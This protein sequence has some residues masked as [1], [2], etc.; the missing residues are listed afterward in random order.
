[1]NRILAT[2]VFG[3]SLTGCIYTPKYYGD[4]CISRD[5][6]YC[7]HL[8]NQW[9]APMWGPHAPTIGGKSEV[10]W[11]SLDKTWLTK[12]IT[13]QRYFGNSSDDSRN[14]QIGFSPDSRFLTL[15]WHGKLGCIELSHGKYASLSSDEESVSSFAWV[16]NDEIQYVGRSGGQPVVYRH[17]VT[18]PR[19]PRAA[20]FVGAGSPVM[21]K[22][23]IGES[24][25]PDGKFLSY[26][27]PADGVKVLD[28]T[29]V[30]VRFASHLSGG[31]MEAAWKTDNS[32]FF[33]VIYQE[34][35]RNPREALYVDTTS[36]EASDRT[37]ELRRFV[38]S[39]W[40]THLDPVWTADNKY[41]VLNS[42]LQGG[43]LV[44]PSSWSE[45]RIGETLKE[46][47]G[48]L[49]PEP[50]G[51]DVGG[52]CYGPEAHRSSIVDWVFVTAKGKEYFVNFNNFDVIPLPFSNSGMHQNTTMRPGSMTAMHLNEFNGKIAS[53]QIR[54]GDAKPLAQ[55]H[56][57]KQGE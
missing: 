44:D 53:F 48:C 41:I 27:T 31:W 52:V 13:L 39:S 5:D 9:S 28:T 10:Q 20:V 55:F 17:K 32:G 30:Q 26:M 49:M 8:E 6:R 37:E 34:Y 25:S 57:N 24:W 3:V 40:N 23:P 54:P 43:V 33:V 42:S 50:Y 47:L 12:R 35:G 46:H 51:Y 7:A 36:W 29:S 16:S 19:T 11:C 1:M 45:I 15:L 38:G 2:V 4:F 18:N 22:E 56:L 14:K 21:E